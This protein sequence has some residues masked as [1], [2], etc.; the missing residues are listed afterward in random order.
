[1]ENLDD[2]MLPYCDDVVGLDATAAP[3]W[4]EL[5]G[6]AQRETLVMEPVPVLRSIF[7]D[8]GGVRTRA[9]GVRRLAQRIGTVLRQH[10]G[11]ASWI[12]YSAAALY[13][14]LVGK[15]PRAVQ[16]LRVALSVGVSNGDEIDHTMLR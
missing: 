4:D 14:R 1:M 13:W 3:W 9:L 15:A 8:L 10:K 12:V 11:V 2:P 5:D 7:L 6:V 16:C